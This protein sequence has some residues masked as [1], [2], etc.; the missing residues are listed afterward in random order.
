MK[1]NLEV[2]EWAYLTATAKLSKAWG[3]GNPAA[4]AHVVN[5]AS[6]CATRI[7][8]SPLGKRRASV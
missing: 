5:V 3:V 6:L 8:R 1:V 4:L 2:P 7:T